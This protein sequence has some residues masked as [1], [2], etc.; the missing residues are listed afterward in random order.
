MSTSGLVVRATP[1]CGVGTGEHV[2]HTGRDVGVVGDQLAER[3]RDQRRIRCA[4]QHNGASGRERGRELGQRELRR[5]VVRDDR[6]HHPGS[7]LLHPAVVLHAV[8]LAVAEILGQRVRLQQ[9]R[10][11]SARSRSARR[12]GRPRTSQASHRPRRWSARRARRGGR[13]GPGAT[14]RG[15]GSATRCWW[16]SRWC[17][18]LAAP[19]RPRPRR[20]PPSRPGRGRPPLPWRG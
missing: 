9:I 8:A 13:P 10:V 1:T 3:K 7:L 2:D 20:R 4:L 16:T 6:R 11:V 18:T 5:V 17:R 15:S 14:G 19:R 12:V